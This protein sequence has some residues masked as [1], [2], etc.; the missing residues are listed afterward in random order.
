[1]KLSDYIAHFVAKQGV[2]HVFMLPGG[3]SMH[4]VDSFGRNP[5]LTYIA[6]LHEQA[7]GF[8]A[9]AY[10]EC[11]NQLGVALLTSGPGAT[12]GVTPVA[13][14]WIESS[15]CLFISGQA[16][17]DDMI[18][19]KGVR[20]MGHQ[21]VDIISV[22]RP[23]TK[24]AVTILDP[25]SI[26]YHLEKAVYLATHGRPGPVWVEVPLDVQSSLIDEKKLVGFAPDPT[27]CDTSSDVRESVSRMIELVKNSA[28]P[29][30]LIGNGVR[31]AN[32]VALLNTLLERVK[33]PVLLTWKAVDMLP[34]GHPLYRGRP[35]GIGQRGA[36]FTQQNSDCLIIVGARLDLP[37]LAFDHLNFARAAK[38]IMVDIDPAEI[39]KMQTPID[40]PIC[41]DAQVFLKEFINQSISLTGYEPTDWLRQTLE[42]QRNYPVVIP[43]YRQ[44]HMGYVSS[45]LFNDILSEELLPSDVI[46]TGGA[47]ASSDILMQT[48]KVKKGQRIF[49]IP[50]I[51]AMGSGIPAAIG[52]CLAAGGR[53]TV[54]VDGDGGF[55]LN[56]QELETL[57][58]LNLQVKI[59][60]L[61]NDGYGSIRAMQQSR[62]GGRLVAADSTSTLTLP[63]VN[64]IAIAYGIKTD[65]LDDNANI[66]ETVRRV[67]ASDGPVVCVVIVSPSECTAPRVLSVLNPDGSMTPKPM[68]DMSPLLSRDEFMKNMIIPPIAD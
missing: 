22:V 51:G 64:K 45:Y 11:R 23:I 31:S 9:E 40:L 28:R 53:R 24:Y 1:M 15:G 37:S 54:C 63:D 25:Q 38:K 42:W 65:K 16:K 33:I 7:C 68:E 5:D 47:G 10:A 44:E 13:T 36:N 8:A 57:R 49:N 48:F 18:G 2:N 34:E 59:F 27:E 52:G 4:L 21:E 67:L 41:A 39:W 50:G 61:N 30:L 62:F 17:R 29:V 56:I 6:C 43:E 14:A 58:R 26:R 12:N 19:T 66:R 35:G 55:Q 3:G 20:S 32:A 46:T 60:V